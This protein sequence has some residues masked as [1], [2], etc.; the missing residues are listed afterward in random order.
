MS[1]TTRRR[2]PPD[3][4]DPRQVA[5]LRNL[6]HLLDAR[7]RFPGTNWRFG[8]DGVASIVPV[9]GDS[10]TAVI[11]LYIIAQAARLGIPKSTL[12]R[13]LGNVGIDW[14][15]GSVPVIGTMFDLAFKSNLRNMRLLNKHLDTHES[16]EAERYR[17]KV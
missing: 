10:A 4:I 11:G 2:Q 17:N 8:V 5:A 7:W 13:M 1:R 6:A 9:L 14:A 16:R 15:F 3:A 12:A